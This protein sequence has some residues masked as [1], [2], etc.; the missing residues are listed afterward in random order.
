M[1]AIAGDPPGFAVDEDPE[2]LGEGLKLPPSLERRR[3]QLEEVLLPL[4][5]PCPVEPVVE[6]KKLGFEHR[7]LPG[8]DESAPTLLLL[9]GTGGD[10]N[11][12][13]PLGAELAPR[14]NLLSP[15]GK[16]L[17]HGMPRFFRRLGVDD[18]RNRPAR[19]AFEDHLTTV[20]HRP[21]AARRRCLRLAR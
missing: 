15:R 8:R 13:I 18:L 20:R 9:H 1:T 21:R 4:R 19:E 17:E 14:A 7:F 3:S 12:L 5:L 16:V 6:Q 2:H 10:E 11:D